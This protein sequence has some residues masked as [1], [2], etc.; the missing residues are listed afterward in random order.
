MNISGAGLVKGAPNKD[1]AIKLVRVF[2]N[3]RSSRAYCK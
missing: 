3:S 1:N 2:I